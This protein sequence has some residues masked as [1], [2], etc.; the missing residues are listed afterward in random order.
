MFFLVMRFWGL[1]SAATLA[2]VA[3]AQLPSGFTDTPVVTGLSLPTGMAFAPDGRL[4]I[5]QK[6]GHIRLVK[7]G[8]LQANDFGL[9]ACESTAGR[10]LLGITFDPQFPTKPYVYVYYTAGA[11]SLQPP[12]TPKNR[13]SRFRVSG[14]A[15]VPGTEIILVDGIASDSGSDNGGTVRFGADEN[16]YISTGDGGTTHTNSQDLASLNGKI[17]RINRNGGIP[18][19]NPFIATAGARKEIW[20][21]GLR[22]PFRFA[23]QPGTSI[24]YIADNG[25]HTWEEVNVGVA[26][27]NYGWPIY[28]GPTTDPNFVAPL[29]SYNHN[30][31]SRSIIA[32]Q[33]G[34][35][36]KWPALYARRFLFADY[37]LNTIYMHDLDGQTEVPMFDTF[38]SCANGPVDFAFG[39]DGALYYVAILE[40]SVHKIAYK[41]KVV[42]LSAPDRMDGGSTGMASVT[43]NAVAPASN[44][45]VALSSSLPAVL[46][47][48][49]SVVVP[50]GQMLKEFSLVT[51][52]VVASTPVTIRASLGVTVSATVT[53]VPNGVRDMFIPTEVYSG[54]QM[55]ITVFLK[56]LASAPAV[57]AMSSDSPAVSISPSIT[58]PAGGHY[59]TTTAWAAP[60]A[61]ETPATITASW[62]GTSWSETVNVLPARLRTL[63]VNPTTIHG[64]QNGTG[65]VELIGAGA[66]TVVTLYDNTTL[67]ETPPSVTVPT[68]ATQAEFIFTTKPVTTTGVR[69]ITAKLGTNTSTATVTLI[70]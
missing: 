62:I 6:A 41:V 50:S 32:G 60:V 57:V 34:K 66:N 1:L 16:L 61:T 24:P 14:D 18:A 39:P 54:G 8:V 10:G 51:N 27:G 37:K 65:T 48:P 30:G 2:C 38:G 19:G 67:I 12:A 68:G 69:T 44:Q 59:Q 55:S 47:V 23:F 64:G 25:D 29:F 35:S 17:L 49:S 42:S 3:H 70:R 45:S 20:A 11:N 21:W 58:I 9:V 31:G 26:G 33:F 13:V 4:V 22:N 15:I 53:V 52:S 40:G 63:S 56:G 7:S 5:T 36:T 46:P 43:L 28:E